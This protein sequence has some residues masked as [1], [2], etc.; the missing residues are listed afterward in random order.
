MQGVP[1]SG[2][3]QLR[4]SPNC[5]AALLLRNRSARRGPNCSAAQVAE[6]LSL[7]SSSGSSW[8]PSWARSCSAAP[9]SSG[10]QAAV[11]SGLRSGR[12][13]ARPEA[14]GAR[15]ALR[16]RLGWWVNTVEVTGGCRRHSSGASV[17]WQQVAGSD[18]TSVFGGRAARLGEQR[19]CPVHLV[20]EAESACW[21]SVG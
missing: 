17:S 18:R 19:R 14:S 11:E 15:T 16:T 2:A 3:V 12:V 13:A 8:A 20:S 1:S 9:G 6:Q 10:G 4:D 21:L 7:P 5:S